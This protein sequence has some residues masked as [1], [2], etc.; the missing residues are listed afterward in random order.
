MFTKI[1]AEKLTKQLLSFSIKLL[2]F[3]IFI[4]L[5]LIDFKFF[6]LIFL[7]IVVSAFL[8]KFGSP[9]GSFWY[10]SDVKGVLESVKKSSPSRKIIYDLGSGDGRIVMAIAKRFRTRVIGI[11][12]NPLW[13]LL[14]SIGIRVRKLNKY[15]SIKMANFFKTPLHNGDIIVIYLLP[16]TLEKLK[17][18]LKKELKKGARV[19]SVQFPINRWKHYK[20][21]K[22]DVGYNIYLYKIK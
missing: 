12:I 9:F 7:P 5:L 10:P 6:F 3:Y 19:I 13:V 22:S 18:K 8:V 15:A 17:V 16:K 14:S 11:E 20:I 4:S 1:K 2:V 21:V